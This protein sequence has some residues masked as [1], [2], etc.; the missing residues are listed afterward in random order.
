MVRSYS[1]PTVILLSC[2]D[3][4]NFGFSSSHEFARVPIINRATSS[5]IIENDQLI[6]QDEFLKQRKHQA[7][8]DAASAKVKRIK[9]TWY[10]AIAAYGSSNLGKSLWQLLNT[11]IPYCLLWALMLQTVQRGYSYWITLTLALLAG[12]MMVRI[13]IFFHDCCHGSF[14]ASRSANTILGYVSGIATFTPF[15][16]W[17]YAHNSHHATAGD[18]DRRGI[19]DI[20][21]MT[22]E[23]YLAASARKTTQVSNLSEPFRL[24]WSGRG[25]FVFIYPAISERGRRKEGAQKRALHQLGAAVRL[26]AWQA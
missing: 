1:D 24:V 13:F 17:K 22:K 3:P 6:T 23:E 20:W 5:R 7:L 10:N 4:N 12:G 8:P 21:T 9:P 19:G 25:A 26:S 18:L 15:E 2:S 16:D 11:F 14:F